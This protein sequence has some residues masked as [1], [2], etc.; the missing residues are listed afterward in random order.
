MDFLWT[1]TILLVLVGIVASIIN[2]VAGGGSYLTLPILIFTGLPA[3]AANAT[4]RVGILVGNLVGAWKFA[5]AGKLRK[6]DLLY[7]CLPAALGGLLGAYLATL[8]NDNFLRIFLAILMLFGSWT[9]ITKPNREDSA[10]E[11]T[12]RPAKS[13]PLFSAVGTYAGFIQAG[14]GFFSLA[15]SSALGYGLKRGNAIK[16]LM[17]LCLTIPALAVFAGK[18]LVNWPDGVALAVGMAFG[19]AIGV[20]ISLESEPKNLRKMVAGAIV[21]SAIMIVYPLVK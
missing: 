7:F 8:V 17:N 13:F 9:V 14:T 4:N 2:I 3:T 6:T 18:A 20:R 12:P 19:S 16:T 5:R 21:I 15:A 11:P 1:H 10:Q